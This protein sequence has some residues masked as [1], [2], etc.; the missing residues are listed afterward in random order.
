MKFKS[1]L[2]PLISDTD[3]KTLDKKEIAE[4]LINRFEPLK[5]GIDKFIG[6]IKTNDLHELDIKLEDIC[7][8]SNL[9]YDWLTYCLNTFGIIDEEKLKID[10]EFTS[11]ISNT[12]FNFIYQINEIIII[13][14]S[15][16]KVSPRLKY[17]KKYIE[18]ISEN[19]L[20][21][22]LLIREDLVK[23]WEVLLK[24]VKSSKTIY[25][26]ILEIQSKINRIYYDFTSLVNIYKRKEISTQLKE[27]LIE[28]K[29]NQAFTRLEKA[30]DSFKEERWDNAVGDMRLVLE[31]TVIHLVRVI[32]NDNYWNKPFKE[33]IEILRI[34]GIIKD[35][36]TKKHFCDRNISVYSALS[37]KGHHADGTSDANL[38]NSELEARYFMSLTENVI[39]YLLASFRESEFHTKE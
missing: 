19:I 15:E 27:L 14:L 3:R 39:E 13:N 35:E 26:G 7:K 34:N 2:D 6:D 20:K 33:G 21:N 12:I 4:F 16:F 31:M 37:M 8:Y 29:L 36:I 28:F 11:L 22:V 38:A 1:T 25:N 5:K 23:L 24:I 10:S 9:F 17:P 32:L 30:E 18:E